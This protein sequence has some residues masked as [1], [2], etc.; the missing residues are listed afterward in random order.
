MVRETKLYVDVAGVI[1]GR[2]STPSIQTLQS[3]WWW[4][5]QEH[6]SSRYIIHCNTDPKQSQVGWY[7]IS[8]GHRNS[9]GHPGATRLCS[10]PALLGTKVSPTSSCSHFLP[11]GIWRLHL[12][13]SA[14]LPG[15]HL[16]Q[17]ISPGISHHCL[18]MFLITSFPNLGSAYE[19]APVF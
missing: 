14:Q 16:E 11:Y 1:G 8:L 13:T 15:C 6:M 9:H 2:K 19:Q 17:A 10:A 7:A 4:K 12:S 3:W 5:G 18:P